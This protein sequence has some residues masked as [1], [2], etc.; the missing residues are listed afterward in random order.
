MAEKAKKA[1]T[2]ATPRK[3]TAKKDLAHGVATP[4]HQAIEQLAKNLWAERG[5]RDGYAEQDWLRAEQT[6]RQSAL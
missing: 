5:Y 1:K 2:P 3:S 4:S 6:L